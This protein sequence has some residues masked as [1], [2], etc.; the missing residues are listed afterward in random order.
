[1]EA[2]SQRRKLFVMFLKSFCSVLGCII[3]L[4]DYR[5]HEEVHLVCNNVWVCSLCQSNIHMVSRLWFPIRTSPRASHHLLFWRRSDPEISC[6]SIS[7]SF[8]CPFFQLPT[9]Q[10][11]FRSMRDIRQLE[12]MEEFTRSVPLLLYVSAALLNHN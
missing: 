3:L 5:Y 1:M 10:I 4:R 12:R 2:K 7:D 6:Q 8:A 11:A 9:H